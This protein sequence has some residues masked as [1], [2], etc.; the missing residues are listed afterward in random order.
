MARIPNRWCGLALPLVLA[1]WT[2]AAAA[3]EALLLSSDGQ[4]LVAVDRAAPATV[5]SNTTLSGL[6]QG[7]R[8]LGF[9]FR[10]AQPRI[11]YGI[12]STGRVYVINRTTGVASQIGT[13]ASLPSLSGSG[14]TVDFN[15]VPDA[16]RYISNQPGFQQSLRF[17]PVSGAVAGSD[18][19]V[20]FV[21]LPNEPNAGEAARVVA[22]AYTEN[23]PGGRPV[24]NPAGQTVGSTTLYVI[25]ANRGVLATQGTPGFFAGAPGGDSPNNGGLRTVGTLGVS[26]TADAGLDIGRDGAVFAVL[27]DPQTNRSSLYTVELSTGRA[28]LVGILA[29]DQSFTDLALALPSFESIARQSSGRTGNAAA[30]GR[31]LDRYEG[32]ANAD[33][34]ALFR[35]ADA[36]PQSGVAP[37][38]ES[39][40]GGILAAT[41]TAVSALDR[42][43]AA[44]SLASL[45]WSTDG[46]RLTVDYDRGSTNS[47]GT[48]PGIGWSSHAYAISYAGIVAPGLTLG[49]SLGYREIDL[50]PRLAQAD[51]EGEGVTAHAL[52]QYDFGPAYLSLLGGYS[53]VSTDVQRRVS[54][55]AVDQ[56]SRASFDVESRTVA[57]EIG[58]RL[59][60]PDG[61]S[62]NPHVGLIHTSLDQDSFTEDGAGALS[63]NVAGISAAD[64]A[65]E[66][67]A[68]LGGS[69]T[70]SNGLTL[71]PR[72]RV[73]YSHLLRDQRPA[74]SA[75]LPGLGVGSFQASVN[76]EPEDQFHLGLGLEAMFS[77][78]FS[79]GV[80][81][82]GR[83]ADDS[84]G[85]G[86]QA[87][88]RLKF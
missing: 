4:R 35:E 31:A 22:G 16:I 27:T 52:A 67:G 61:F 30:V 23:R 10:P 40:A 21:N 6:Q 33:L 41:P 50:S 55:G 13:P 44:R 74:V 57:A 26:T 9:D 5:L 87:T 12:G 46:A 81:Y 73:A 39:L 62:I 71:L 45:P 82:S 17:S 34:L 14:F 25:E 65:V 19:L 86:L 68:R 1:G 47:N 43:A 80:H 3:Q 70:L 24:V 37:A 2:G 49:G 77:P 20:F 84:S 83:F 59:A 85:Q 66:V 56:A 69:V 54:V 29:G 7:E 63:L 28:T 18:A 79:V 38:L 8:L 48:L 32:V 64:T 78:T 60:L 42:V 88:L 51:V 75:S 15:P 36:L 53:N 76:G 58:S 11:L 72:L